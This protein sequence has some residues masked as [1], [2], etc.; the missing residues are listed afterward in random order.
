MIFTVTS[1]VLLN[2]VHLAVPAVPAKYVFSWEDSLPKQII[3]KRQRS[4]TYRV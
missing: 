4:I 3:N 2:L 1:D